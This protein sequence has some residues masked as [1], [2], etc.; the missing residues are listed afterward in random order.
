MKSID[1]ETAYDFLLQS[2]AILLEGR[3]LELGYL[4]LNGEPDN[5]FLHIRWEECD[6]VFDLTFKEDDNKK[7]EISGHMMTLVNSDGEQEEI[8]LLREFNIEEMV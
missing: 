3:P 1:L 8:E 4:G 6:L 5:E 2:P 7:V